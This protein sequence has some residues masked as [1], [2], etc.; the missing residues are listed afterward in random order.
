MKRLLF[1]ISLL[2]LPVCGKAQNA[3][4]VIS[5]FKEFVQTSRQYSAQFTYSLVVPQENVNYKDEGKSWVKDQW[6][7]LELKSHTIYM[8][9]QSRWTFTPATQEVVITKLG[10]SPEDLLANPNLLILRYLK[11]TTPKL[12]LS[13][14]DQFEIQLS[15]KDTRSSFKQ[16]ILVLNARTY[17]PVRIQYQGKD[18]TS[19]HVKF[20]KFNQITGAFPIQD[21]SFNPQKYKQAEIIDMR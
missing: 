19:M 11:N 15:P 21:I 17:A 9:G 3:Q 12:T 7:K 2:V 8:D 14:P 1:Y 6:A 13:T 18:G 16:I 5:H 4:D 10:T 20:V